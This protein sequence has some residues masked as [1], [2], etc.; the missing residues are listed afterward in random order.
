MFI[1]K[2]NL[3]RC[4]FI[5][6]LVG[7]FVAGVAQELPVKNDVQKKSV[8][9]GNKKIRLT[10]DYNGKANIAS[11]DVNGQNVIASAAGIYSEVR[12]A[13]ANYSSLKL[14]SAPKVEITSSIIK[15]RGISYGN[16]SLTINETWKFTITNTDIKFNV[17]RSF[18]ARSNFLNT[19]S[20]ISASSCPRD[21]PNTIA[22][23]NT[24]SSLFFAMIF[25]CSS[26]KTL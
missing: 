6:V 10:L 3:I 9:F 20:L 15:L 25:W 21:H 26:L 11:L 16:K 17:E 7:F 18:G 24:S 8:V 2:R 1:N 23:L 14:V 5:F 13:T 4:F 22:S 12:T 19:A